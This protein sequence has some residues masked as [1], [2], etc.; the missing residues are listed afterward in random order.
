MSEQRLSKLQRWI[1]ENCFRVT[2][3]LDRT[4]LKELNNIGRS[5]RCKACNKTSASV[6]LE[7]NQ[8]N[9]VSPKCLAD[10]N[11][12]AYFEF[13][14]EDILLSYFQLNPNN[15]IA[16]INRVQHFRDSTDYTKAHVT[17]HRSLNN[18]ALKGLIYTGSTFREES[19]QI[20]LTR[21]GVKTAAELLG[22]NDCE[23]LIEP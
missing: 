1:L 12:C 15:G 17:A 13:Y 21:E 8:G 9:F 2:V 10:G 3:L 19:L 6:Y 7:R 14:K 23:A 18:L 11:S 22:I 4:I 20:S 5:R 16:H